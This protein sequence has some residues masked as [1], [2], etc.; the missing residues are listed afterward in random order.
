MNFT[1]RYH[2][3]GVTLKAIKATRKAL[4]ANEIIQQLTLHNRLP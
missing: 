2:P 4:H 1:Y 3:A